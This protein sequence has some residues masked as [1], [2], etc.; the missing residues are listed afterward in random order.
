[1]AFEGFWASGMAAKSLRTASEG[2]YLAS[3]TRKIHDATQ[4]THPKRH[5]RTQKRKKR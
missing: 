3:R 4:D 2:L 5:Q 1:M